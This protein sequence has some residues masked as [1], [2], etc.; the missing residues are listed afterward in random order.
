MPVRIGGPAVAAGIGWPAYFVIA[1][2]LYAL[3]F[4][5]LRRAI[6]ATLANA[7]A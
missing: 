4:L 5:F 2:A 1:A 6:V 3:A 7:K